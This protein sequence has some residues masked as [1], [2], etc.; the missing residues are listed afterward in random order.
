MRK[1]DTLVPLVDA[2]G[3]E[4][5]AVAEEEDVVWAATAA[6]EDGDMAIGDGVGEAEEVD[7]AMDRGSR[8]MVCFECLSAI[9]RIAEFLSLYGL[10]MKSEG[11]TAA[12]EM[13]FEG[14]YD[15]QF[16]PSA[17]VNQQSM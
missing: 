3:A 10:C 2:E 11:G 1:R 9:L 8:I 7:L 13:H 4:A 17:P 12:M 6:V 16:V 14:G 5:V 15:R